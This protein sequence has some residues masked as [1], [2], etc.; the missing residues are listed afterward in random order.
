MKRYNLM[1]CP[2]DVTDFL[3]YVIFEAKHRKEVVNFLQ[4]FM[5][6]GKIFTQYLCVLV[7]NRQLLF[8]KK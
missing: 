6:A 2:E 1:L 7:S 8:L 4:N 3:L 5:H